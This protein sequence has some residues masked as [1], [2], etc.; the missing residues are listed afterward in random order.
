MR[1]RPA[2]FYEHIFKRAE[3]GFVIQKLTETL[4]GGEIIFKGTTTTI[5]PWTS[6][7]EA[8]YTRS[9][10]YLKM[11]LSSEINL[12]KRDVTLPY[13]GLNYST[14]SLFHQL[15]YLKTFFKAIKQIFIQSD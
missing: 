6:N 15:L 10:Y 3:T 2:G 1:G 14:P 11:I 7:Y 4:D 9:L 5:F 8:V 13:S 12:L